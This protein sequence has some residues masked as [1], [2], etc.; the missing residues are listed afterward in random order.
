SPAIYE[1]KSNESLGNLLRMAG[2]VTAFGYSERLQLER[3]QNHE[4]RVALDVNLNQR[5]AGQ[6]PVYDGDLV[7]VFTV[8][9]AERNV[10]RVKGNVNQPGPYEW[11][12]GMKVMD[13]MREAQG[14]SDHTFFEY[15]V[16]ERREGPER[17]MKPLAIN[18]GEALSNQSSQDDIALNPEDT[19][20]VYSQNELG[21]VSTVSIVGE[22][23][24]PGNYPLTPGMTVRELVYGAGGLLE[25]ASR[26]RAMLTRTE[27]A[28]GSTAAYT[29]MDVDLR[30]ILNPSSADD[31]TL[32]PGDELLVQQ[33]SNWHAPWHVI[34]QGQ[35]TRPGPYPIREGER[36][37]AVLEA[38][39]GFL[40]DAYPR[41]A[42]F[43]RSS[44][45]DLQ[46]A[47]LDQARAHLQEDVAR[48]TLTPKAAGQADASAESLNAI[49]DML[50]QS[51]SQ[52]AI[53]RIV[54]HIS[55][56]DALERSPDNIVL[57]NG[58]KLVIPA[59][60]AAVQV[61]GQVY[62]PNAI[63]YQPGLRA[64]DYLQQ[65]GGPTQGGDIDHI[66]V[67]KADGSVLTDAGVR[68]SKESRMFPLLPVISGGLMAQRLE[69]GD[70]IY[71]P[72]KLVYVSSLQYAKDIT[73]I[74]SNTAM[75]L[76]VI[77]LLAA[78]L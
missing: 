4:K 34:L 50:S 29:H 36:L 16:V 73:Q 76:G 12:P 74:V 26:D 41:A 56:I 6:F 22:V 54:I 8:L 1:I 53:G 45:K 9:P 70:T 48:I 39:G 33:A 25:N 66:Y 13:L 19:L 18:L 23:R 35:V 10:V 7:K 21:Q 61:L 31:L 78:S 37:A 68:E 71:V 51:A 5:S 2:G 17:R 67:I 49:K 14:P 64:M 65:A 59:R 3:V 46:Q 57:E 20:V 58:D 43:I 47:Q 63:V 42:V 15:A 60:P 11:H 62:N 24:K 28:N 69:P 38:C 75:S 55:S 52:Q 77:G 72:E 44:V 27:I 30:K 40:P 32:K